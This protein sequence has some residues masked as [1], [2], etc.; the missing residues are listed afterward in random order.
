MKLRLPVILTILY[1]QKYEPVDFMSDSI[2]LFYGVFYI[3]HETPK[4]LSSVV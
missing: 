3:F 1:E 4:F 2:L